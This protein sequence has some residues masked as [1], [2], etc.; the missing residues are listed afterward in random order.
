MTIIII[1][2]LSLALLNSYCYYS[3][4]LL[5]LQYAVVVVLIV[6]GEITTASVGFAYRGPI[7]SC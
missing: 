6:L 5:I 1:I 7:V 2:K 4:R 3:G